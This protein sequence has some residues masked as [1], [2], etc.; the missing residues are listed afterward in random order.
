MYIGITD[1]G[2]VLGVP[3]T[4]YQKDHF[5]LN[6]QDT[7]SRFTPPV[8]EDMYLVRY[9]PI[10]ERKDLAKESDSPIVPIYDS[11][12]RDTPHRLRSSVY[13]W[14]DNDAKALHANVTQH[15]QIF[16]SYTILISICRERWLNVLLSK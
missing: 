16:F 2:I 14:C 5:L 12:Q 7:L 1:N 13:C 15:F 8:T 11:L 4:P 6:V 3:L 10:I 9:I